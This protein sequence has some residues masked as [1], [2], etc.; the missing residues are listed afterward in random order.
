MFPLAARLC[1]FFAQLL[2]AASL[3]VMASAEPL[4]KSAVRRTVAPKEFSVGDIEQAFEAYLSESTTRDLTELL[5]ELKKDVKW[6]TAPKCNIMA[7]YHTLY[8]HVVAIC[9]AGVLPPKRTSIAL[10]ALHQKRPCNFSGR[11]EADWADDLS[12]AIRAGLSKFREILMD[13]ASYK[14]CMTKASGGEKHAI[15]DVLSY[16]TS[17]DKL[18]IDESL[19]HKEPC[20]SL[21]PSS[22]VAPAVQL[23]NFDTLGK[24]FDDFD[25]RMGEYDP[26]EVL[27]IQAPRSAI[28]MS[29]SRAHSATSFA[30]TAFYSP[31]ASLV[32]WSFQ[33]LVTQARDRTNHS[34][35]HLGSDKRDAM[36]GHKMVVGC[37]AYP[38]AKLC[39]KGCGL[40]QTDMQ[41]IRARFC[42]CGLQP[43]LASPS[44]THPIRAVIDS[45]Y[46]TLIAGRGGRCTGGLG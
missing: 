11:R 42:A 31:A 35:S 21:V 4:L 8:K 20:L 6:K 44:T 7:K 18:A 45:C 5:S 25:K 13:P 1:L 28:S 3:V 40:S 30:S 37:V 41:H 9:P 27:N 46:H 12:V 39:H 36:H 33:Y 22:P 23:L 38:F 29:L 2:L 14:R 24:F 32:H 34:V 43:C 15:D 19:S 17:Q 16:M 26:T 10:I